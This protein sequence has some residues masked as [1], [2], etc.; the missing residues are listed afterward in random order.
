MPRSDAE[1]RAANAE[2]AK[3][4]IEKWPERHRAR[5][6]V[7]HAIRD[8]RLIRPD[9]CQRCGVGCVPQGSHDDY[10]HPLDVEWLCKP[11]HIAKDLPRACRHGHAYTE[12]N[13]RYPRGGGRKCK[14]CERE[15]QRMRRG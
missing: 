12:E 1:R 10:T 6:A 4:S 8:G 3:R 9:K 2:S 13:T 5:I 11:C 15:Q 7:S 14:T